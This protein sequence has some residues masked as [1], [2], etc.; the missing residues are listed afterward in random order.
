MSLPLIEI[1]L[2]EKATA[3]LERMSDPQLVREAVR[4]GMDEAN[5]L[6]VSTIQRDYLS[7]PKSGPPVAEGL[8]HQSGDYRRS[9]RASKAVI[10]GD[11][12]TSGIGSS[13]TKKGFSYPRLHEFGG[14]VKRKPRGGIVRL[15]TDRAG[16]LLRQ[17]DGKLAVFAKKRDRRVK[18]VAYQGKAYEATYPA[19][20]PIQR[21]ITASIDRT[22]K[23]VSRHII[24]AWNGQGGAA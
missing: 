23:I 18:E 9:L 10:N 24:A 8:R 21:G 7:F 19:R 5:L 17:A 15:K 13:V 1:K 14:T 16:V 20:A 12:V 6:I 3:L 22:G 2:T 4:R 11:S